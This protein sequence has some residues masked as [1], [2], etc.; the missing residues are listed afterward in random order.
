[1]YSLTLTPPSLA[2]G[3]ELS[4]FFSTRGRREVTELQDQ[5][6][7]RTFSKKVLATIRLS[8][9]AS[10]SYSTVIRC[11]V[12]S[13]T[14]IIRSSR[15]SRSIGGSRPGPAVDVSPLSKGLPA[16]EKLWL[17]E[18]EPL[19]RA[20]G[21]NWPTSEVL[22]LLAFSSLRGL[23]SW[24]LTMTGAAGSTCVLSSNPCARGSIDWNSYRRNPEGKSVRHC[25]NMLY[26]RHDQWVVSTSMSHCSLAS[27]VCVYPF[28]FVSVSF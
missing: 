3:R 14:P 26:H 12:F 21:L 24:S 1:M 19:V 15:P 9:R 13:N 2:P 22:D 17:V 20:L 16:W 4:L 23:L 11:R 6:S 25:S 10:P 8:F 18:P 28:L 7:Y 27:N 5:A